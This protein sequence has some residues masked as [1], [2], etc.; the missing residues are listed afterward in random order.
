MECTSWCSRLSLHRTSELRS[1]CRRHSLSVSETRST[2]RKIFPSRAWWPKQS[3]ISSPRWRRP[4]EEPFPNAYPRSSEGDD[5]E[6]TPFS[7][8]SL[9]GRAKKCWVLGSEFS[10][11]TQHFSLISSGPLIPHFSFRIPQNLTVS[12]G[13]NPELKTQNFFARPASPTSTTLALVV[14]RID[15]R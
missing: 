13:P 12:S 15:C 11:R 5:N 1:L 3:K 4:T 10:F 2:G 9:E 8:P 7:T 6:S 14:L